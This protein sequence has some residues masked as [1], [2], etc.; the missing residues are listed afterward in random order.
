MNSHASNSDESTVIPDGYR[1][2]A[3]DTD[4]ENASLRICV[5]VRA[6]PDEAGG[7]LVLL[8][9]LLHG[10]SLLGCVIDSGGVVHQWLEIWVQD[11]EGLAGSPEV[12]RESCCNAAMDRQWGEVF[13][14]ART[15]SPG[16]VVQT[17][18]E[19]TPPFP[20]CLDP[21]AF[22]PVQLLD[23]K[24]GH[25]LALCRDEALLASAGLPAY[26]SSTQRYLHVPELGAESP[27][28][29][30]TAEAPRTS[31]TAELQDI[32]DGYPDLIGFNPGAGLL[33]ARKFSPVDLEPY[34]DILGGAPWSGVF[35]G[36]TQMAL[37]KTL[38][39]LS[40]ATFAERAAEGHLLLAKSGP[41][42]RL[43]EILHLKL[44]AITDAVAGV[45]EAIKAVQRPL[46]G[47][48]PGSFRVEFG[49][50]GRGL[51]FLWNARLVQ[52]VPGE[53][54]ELPIEGSELRYYLPGGG[55]RTSIYRPVSGQV[56]V[57]GFG[58]LRIRQAVPESNGAI[59][60]E[61]TLQTQE[62]MDVSANDLIWLR[63]RCAGGAANIF[64]SAEAEQAKAAGEVRF[65]SIPQRF[66]EQLCSELRA[67]EGVPVDRVP[68]EMVP[69]L[70]SPCDLYALAVLAVRTLLTDQ[71]Q[72]LPVALDEIM[73]LARVCAEY[74]A[75]DVSAEMRIRGIMDGDPR[76]VE[77][78]GPH[79]LVQDELSPGDAFDH[80]PLDLWCQALA[81]IVRM[82]P[83]MG[84]DSHCRDLGDAT[85]GALHRIFDPVLEELDA[86]LIR[87]RSLI[88]VDWAANRE[89]HA[90]IR[91]CSM[92]LSGGEADAV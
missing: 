32:V 20:T 43:V 3:I 90:V 33:Q 73:S 70:S 1:A 18:W 19:M 54:I 67:L 10:R 74:Y 21:T 35:H 48:D 87:S 31:A 51:P 72:S 47:V 68:F 2:A 9:D 58:R 82:F 45:R 56:P 42:G 53:A 61:G 17:G 84:P 30:V 14:A 37:G 65:R 46:L 36:T 52:V 57:R 39:G 77:S 38:R 60:I 29:P 69:L 8:R 55:E 22:R 71:Q 64:V 34:L 85:P 25:P 16:S 92:G 6:E 59:V 86:L 41:T 88:V 83:G 79:R 66:D 26:G 5:I 4:Q 15:S 81:A 63:V 11:L 80:V 7:Q 91:Q 50:A 78:L 62:R 12:V 23:S 44:R 13:D 40:Q 27:L 49:E 75:D 76:W 89:I 28:V 24:S